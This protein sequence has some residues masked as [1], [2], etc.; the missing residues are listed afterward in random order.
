MS[1]RMPS[2]MD[3]SM[4][5]MVRMDLRGSPGPPSILSMMGNTSWGFTSR[6]KAP[7]RGRMLMALKQVGSGTE[8]RNSW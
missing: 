8:S 4:S 3:C 5:V 7:S 6:A 2:K 1:F